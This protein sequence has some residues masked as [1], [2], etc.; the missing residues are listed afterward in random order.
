MQILRRDVKRQPSEKQSTLDA[1]LGQPGV[2]PALW[3]IFSS[4]PRP[5]RLLR[6]RY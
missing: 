1:G 3:L 2:T 6:V 4:G 5:I